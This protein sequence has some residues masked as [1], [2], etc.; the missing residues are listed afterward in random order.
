MSKKRSGKKTKQIIIVKSIQ[1]PTTALPFT[2]VEGFDGAYSPPYPFETLA[3]TVKMNP[4]H[5]RALHVKAACSTLV[6]YELQQKE[7]ADNKLKDPWNVLWDGGFLLNIGKIAFDWELFG[8]AFIEV[9]RGTGRKIVALGHIPAV[10]MWVTKTGFSQII[11]TDGRNEKIDFEPYG[12]GKEHEVIHLRQYGGSSSVYGLPE[13]IG[14]LNALILDNNSTEWN[15]R[16]FENNLIPGWAIII[17]DG[18][19]DELAEHAIRDYFQQNFKGTSNAHKTLLLTPN[20]SKITF[21]KLQADM[22]DMDFEQMKLSCRNE[23]VSGHGVPPRLLGIMSAAQLGGGGEMEWQLKMFR[24]VTLSTKQ[25]YYEA[26]LNKILAE[27]DPGLT[28][29]FKQI[30]ITTE[31]T[32]IANTKMEI[33]SCTLLPNEAREAKGR[34]KIDGLDEMARVKALG[35]SGGY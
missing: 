9:V 33:E 23:I 28:I 30:D 4:Y 24:D 12:A 19:L 20:G 2:D 35:N 1:S 34:K 14:C 22:K 26:E 21:Q 3:E 7:V 8:N 15:Y 31:T 32:D 11:N 10:T 18:E 17:E 25:S 29:K 16:F 6:G 5:Q 13:W 27:V